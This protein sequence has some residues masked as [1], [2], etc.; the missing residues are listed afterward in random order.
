MSFV[1]TRRLVNIFPLLVLCTSSY[2]CSSTALAGPYTIGI[3]EGETLRGGGSNNIVSESAT[4][5]R[6]LKVSTKWAANGQIRID[7]PAY[8][9]L[10]RGAG[11]VCDGAPTLEVLID[12]NIVLT[13]TYPDKY[14]KLGITTLD[15][16][17]GTYE[18]GARLKNPHVTDECRRAVYMDVVYIEEKPSPTPVNP[19]GEPMPVGDLPG[20]KQVFVDDFNEDVALGNFPLAVKDKWDAYPYPWRDTKGQTTSNAEIGGWYYPQKTVS[21]KDGVLDVWLHSE[22]IENKQKRLVAALLPRIHGSQFP[23]AKGQLYGRY[24]IRF[25]ADMVEGYKTAWLTWPDSE[26]HPRDGEIDFPEGNLTGD[27]QGYMHW[28]N[29]TR[30]DQ[31]YYALSGQSYYDW[32]T[33][34]IEWEPGRVAFYLDGELITNASGNSS[35]WFDKIPNTPMHWVIQTETRLDNVQPTTADQGH[36]EIDWVAVWMKQ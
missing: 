20:W 2:L 31:Q 15:L 10:V 30:G 11:D 3:A 29:A 28:Q 32:H 24:A 13:E 19:S 16:P 9:I 1:S 5:G 34:V 26:V 25:R 23:G 18:I 36:V 14:W 12:G 27:I 35:E 4:S 33:A 8:K 17:A 7:G 21:I 22:I 6:T